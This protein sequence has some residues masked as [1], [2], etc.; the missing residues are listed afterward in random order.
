[1]Q[2]VGAAPLGL[3]ASGAVVGP[4]TGAG[5]AGLGIAAQGSTSLAV[6][7]QVADRSGLL[8]VVQ[9]GDSGAAL[10]VQDGRLTVAAMVVDVSILPGA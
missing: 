2:G 8:A 9:D 7:I 4:I 6:G 10:L 1:M 3:A 5:G